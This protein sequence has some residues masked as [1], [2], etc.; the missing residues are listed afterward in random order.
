MT[1]LPRSWPAVIGA[2]LLVWLPAGCGNQQEGE[3]C[4]IRNFNADCED[5][6]ACTTIKSG[7]RDYQVCCVPG[8]AVANPAPACIQGPTNQ[9]GGSPDAGAAAD[10]GADAIQANADAT[11]PAEVS[12][13]AGV[14][15]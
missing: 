4:D 14:T 2:L 3:R 8:N 15:E 5:G 11:G 10:V 7:A 6:L 1:I 9:G 12:V 13:D